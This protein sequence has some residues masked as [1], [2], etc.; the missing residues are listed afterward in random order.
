MLRIKRLYT[1]MLQTFLPILLMTFV[2]CLFIFLMQFFWRY[3]EEMIGKGLD[4][5]VLVELF[6]YAA[7]GLVPQS[8]PI[9]VLLA[10]LI[11]FGNLGESFELISMK[12]AGISLIQIMKPLIIFMIFVCVGV[13][14][15]QDYVI[16][17][18]QKRMFALLISV[19]RKAPELEIPAG[20]FY[21]QIDGYN[22]YVRGK[23]PETRLLEDVM[24][25]DFSGGFENASIIVA[26]SGYLKM[27]ADKQHLV[28]QLFSGELFENLKK[29]RSAKDNVPYRRESFRTKDILISFDAGFNRMEDSALD[30]QYVSKNRRQLKETADSLGYIVDSL[31][32]LEGERLAKNTFFYVP[33]A[34]HSVNKDQ[35]KV[36]EQSI[37][38]ISYDSVFSSLSKKRQSEVLSTAISRSEMLKQDFMSRSFS[39]SDDD[40]VV[41][42]HEIEW[43]RKFTLSVACL[44]FFFIGAPL[45]AIIRKG[46]LGMPVVISVLLFLFY[47]IIDNTNYKM[48]RD[49]MIPVWQGIWMSS[50]IL[51]MLGAFFTYKAIN[52]STILNADTYI[53][54]FKRV[55]GKRP[56][57][58]YER[59]EVVIFE[60]DYTKVLQKMTELTAACH[61]YLKQKGLPGYIRF[62]QDRSKGELLQEVI[63]LE[64]VIVAELVNSRNAAIILKMNQYPIMALNRNCTPF[65]NKYLNS[66]LGIL[67][68]LGL[69][70]YL[71]AVFYEKRTC[72][73]LEKTIRLNAETEQLIQEELHFES[74]H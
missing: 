39:V 8:L 5:T 19:K 74:D 56:T 28:L 37:R 10:S 18:A 7:V 1:F 57:R 17:E 38:P 68:P 52:D 20:S 42:R 47:H 44:I 40:A 71:Q 46:G 26:D 35:S 73:D 4:S 12:A 63:R 24:I 70:W 60:A 15:F 50:F 65:K 55:F 21:T 58:N 66:A 53:N 45:G 9:A 34:V 25:Y 23:N 2:I 14:F 11:T 67:F 69:A 62:W 29:Q 72:K 64:D 32:R 41:R 31:K 22:L 43:H 54:F 59:K 61:S 36:P 30:D 51:T 13:F 33:K 16:P 27:A 48:A 3:M 6:V 49:G